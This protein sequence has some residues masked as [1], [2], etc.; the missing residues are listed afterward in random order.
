MRSSAIQILNAR[1][2]AYRL[3][4]GPLVGMH[5]KVFTRFRSSVRKYESRALR[6]ARRNRNPTRDQGEEFVFRPPPREREN[7]PSRPSS[8]VF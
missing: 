8:H 1:T 4:S 7:L 6:I 5:L 2:R 3:S